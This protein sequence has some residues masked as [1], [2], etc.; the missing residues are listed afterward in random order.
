[1]KKAIIKN[2]LLFF[3]LLF[4]PEILVAKAP[5]DRDAMNEIAIKVRSRLL[6]ATEDLLGEIEADKNQSVAVWIMGKEL[7]R[8][9]VPVD[10]TFQKER[11]KT[12]AIIIAITASMALE[13]LQNSN[14]RVSS[15]LPINDQE[16][17]SDI[18][19]S[20]RFDAAYTELLFTLNYG[21][22]AISRLKFL[23]NRFSEAVKDKHILY[24]IGQLEKLS[25]NMVYLNANW[26]SG[27]SHVAS[28][29][30][31]GKVRESDYD[32]SLTLIQTKYNIESVQVLKERLRA[33]TS[34]N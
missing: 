10:G 34:W 25:S 7:L 24:L 19:D 17:S 18:N 1:M 12:D 4:I 29:K 21:P 14:A 22:E 8:S 9:L 3:F 5:I 30:P 33:S 20:R 26:G 13:D 27:I 16:A 31:G 11:L 28:K 23:S 32:E 6:S 2:I 15:L